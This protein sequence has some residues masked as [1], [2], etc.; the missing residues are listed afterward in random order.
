[1]RDPSPARR[2]PVEC[3]HCGEPTMPNALADGRLVCSCT[4]ERDLPPEPPPIP[5]GGAAPQPSPIRIGAGR[6][7]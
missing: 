2:E 4:A 1:M 5:A 6:K 7:A 3:R